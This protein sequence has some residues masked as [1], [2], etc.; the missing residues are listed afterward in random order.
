MTPG[1]GM[2]TGAG[3]SGGGISAKVKGWPYGG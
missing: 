2:A 1:G 3:A